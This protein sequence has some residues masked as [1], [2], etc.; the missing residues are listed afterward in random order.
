LLA[1]LTDNVYRHGRAFN[2]E[3]LLTRATGRG[4]RVEPY[5]A[6]LNGKYSDL[7]PPL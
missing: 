1:W 4:L 7:F 3:E 5:L 6:Y 2:A